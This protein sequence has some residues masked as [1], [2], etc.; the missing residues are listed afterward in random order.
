MAVGAT[1]SRVYGMVVFQGMKLSV[2][3]IIV[4][5]ILAAAFASALPDNS[6]DPPDSEIVLA[7]AA[8]V[9]L[10]ILV[11]MMSSYFPARRAAS[12]DPCECLRAE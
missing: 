1:T 9:A 6:V 11:T 12:V 2:C 10:L 5:S 4:G 3:G 8:V 7:Y